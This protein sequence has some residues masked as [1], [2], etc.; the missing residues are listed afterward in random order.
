MIEYDLVQKEADALNMNLIDLVCPQRRCQV[1]KNFWRSRRI[2]CGGHFETSLEQFAQVRF[3][4]HVSQHSAKNDLADLAFAEL[5][6][7]DGL[8]FFVAMPHKPWA[9][10]CGELGFQLGDTGFQRR[11]ILFQ[12]GGGEARGYVLRAVPVIGKDLDEE[13]PLHLAARA[14]WGRVAYIFQPS[15]LFSRSHT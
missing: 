6:N 3:D 1:A 5:Q 14:A 8:D 15:R 9:A 12:L 11:G 2:F 4:A 10:A 7:E 13:Q